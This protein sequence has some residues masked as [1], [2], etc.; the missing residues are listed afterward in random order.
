MFWTRGIHVS[1]FTHAV[2]H[3]LKE[4]NEAIA[5]VWAGDAGNIKACRNGSTVWMCT[6]AFL[7]LC[8]LDEI[9]EYYVIYFLNQ[10]TSEGGR[11]EA[12]NHSRIVGS[13]MMDLLVI[14]SWV[15]N[16]DT[17]VR[18]NPDTNFILIGSTQFNMT[19]GFSVTLWL[20]SITIVLK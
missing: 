2:H 1:S 19:I 5:F 13:D 7:S 9:Q 8:F 3:P 17:I 12:K 14:L 18:S 20:W 4:M 6:E 16:V 15:F 10:E 11:Q